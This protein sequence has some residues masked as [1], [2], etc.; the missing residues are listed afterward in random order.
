[1]QTVLLIEND[2][3]TLV[4][5]ALVLRSFGYTV[6]EAGSQEEALHTCQEHPEPIRLVITRAAVDSYHS[7]ELVTR[8][9]LLRPQMRALFVSDESVGGL[10]DKQRLRCEC[11][12]IQKPFQADTLAKIIRELLSEH[13]SGIAA[14]SLS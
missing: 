12:F 3:A 13:Q 7:R 14:P 8:L 6:L 1:M 4:A 10:A 9:Q 11:A 5:R 2:P